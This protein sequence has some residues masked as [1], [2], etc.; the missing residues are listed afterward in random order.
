MNR[1][2]FTIKL[3]LSGLRNAG[4]EIVVSE[5]IVKNE[6]VEGVCK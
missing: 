1:Y 6:T 2:R 3:I 4:D 5:Y